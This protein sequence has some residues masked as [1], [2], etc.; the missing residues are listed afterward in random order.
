MA[1]MLRATFLLIAACW[2][3]GAALPHGLAGLQRDIAGLGAVLDAES[4]T[5]GEILEHVKTNV[6][7]KAIASAFK[8]HSASSPAKWTP[9]MLSGNTAMRSTAQGRAVGPVAASRRWWT[10]SRCVM[11][12]ARLTSRDSETH[13]L[14]CAPPHINMCVCRAKNCTFH[15]CR[16][17]PR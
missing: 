14:L 2:A 11:L 13:T 8:K 15:F 1:M 9:H 12:D 6:G 7:N 5:A 4:L 16:A 3:T 17:G 10:W